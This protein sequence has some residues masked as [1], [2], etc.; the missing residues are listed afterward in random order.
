ML[1][2]RASSALSP[3]LPEAE[4]LP[5]GSFIQR[6]FSDRLLCPSHRTGWG[7]RTLLDP[8]PPGACVPVACEGLAIGE[9]DRAA[10]VMWV[11]SAGVDAE[12]Q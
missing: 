11:H 10:R 12:V 7:P 9:V 2:C 3:K 8:S 1:Q 6:L 5:G 4:Q